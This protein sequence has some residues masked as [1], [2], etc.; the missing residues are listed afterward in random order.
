MKPEVN[1]LEGKSFEEI[2]KSQAQR[3]GLL[4]LPNR[5]TARYIQGGRVLMEKSNLDFMVSNQMGTVGFLDAKSFAGSKFSFSEI[6][7]HQLDRAVLYNDYSIP[8]GFVVFFRAEKVV[9]FYSGRQIQQKGIGNS[10]SFHEGLYLGGFWNFDL[11]LVL[12]KK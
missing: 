11:G 1:R 3:C 10:F 6:E 12:S 9:C 2:F 8:S 5:L 4:V 7:P